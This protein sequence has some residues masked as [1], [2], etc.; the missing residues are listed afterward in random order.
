MSEPTV[1]SSSYN[2]SETNCRA[3]EKD[4]HQ[5]DIASITLSCK[6]DKFYQP[7]E[8]STAFAKKFNLSSRRGYKIEV[9]K[10]ST[11][12][13]FLS[14]SFCKRYPSLFKISS[15]L[16]LTIINKPI[17]IKTCFKNFSCGKRSEDFKF[18]P[19]ITS[20]CLIVENRGLIGIEPVFHSDFTQSNIDN[21][22]LPKSV[23]TQ[24]VLPP[25]SPVANLHLHRPICSLIQSFYLERTDFYAVEVIAE[26][27]SSYLIS[28]NYQDLNLFKNACSQCPE[29]SKLVVTNLD[30][31]I[32]SPDERIVFRMTQE[33]QFRFLNQKQT[34]KNFYPLDRRP[35]IIS[36]AIE[37]KKTCKL[38]QSSSQNIFP[39]R[40]TTNTI[41]NFK[42]NHPLKV[43]KLVFRPL[44]P[45]SNVSQKSISEDS[46]CQKDKSFKYSTASSSQFYWAKVDKSDSQTTEKDKAESNSTNSTLFQEPKSE[47]F[48]QPPTI[49]LNEKVKSTPNLTP[50]KEE[51]K[52]HLNLAQSPSKLPSSP[53]SSALQSTLLGQIS[54][55]QEQDQKTSSHSL[56]LHDKLREYLNTRCPSQT[57]GGSPMLSTSQNS[58]QTSNL[59]SQEASPRPQL[60]RN[61]SAL[62]DQLKHQSIYS[63]FEGAEK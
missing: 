57:L 40:A 10:L 7:I 36:Q 51:S 4:R 61:A 14:S 21:A 3:F 58:S 46:F 33:C 24:N 32:K 18:I 55:K 6:E 1:L 42:L 49:S 48:V 45:E 15:S 11:S 39:S 16:E 41:R 62:Y 53:S 60:S 13:A 38:N 56:N 20:N 54:Q 25:N 9:G 30:S 63:Y 8:V 35:C 50:L 17:L 22:Q 19:Q 26:F 2:I 5:Q 28:D 37:E 47:K 27:G 59:P 34:V 44:P 29:H 23:Q 12:Y 31:S 52:D 43:E